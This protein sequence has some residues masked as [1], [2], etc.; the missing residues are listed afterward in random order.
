MGLGRI[1][2]IC[3]TL[4]SN[5]RQ[6]DTPV[7]VIQSGT[8]PQQREVY[9]SL[10]NI[11]AKVKDENISSPAIIIV[12]E[13]VGIKDKI[14]ISS[15]KPLSGA[16]VIVTRPQNQSSSFSKKLERLGAETVELAAVSIEENKFNTSCFDKLKDGYF[17][18]VIFT[19]RNGVTHTW[20]KLISL[21]M[22]TRIFG[23]AKVGAIGSATA[24]AL[25]GIGVIADVVPEKFIAE[26]LFESVCQFSGALAGKKILML[27]S[28]IARTNLKKLFEDAGSEVTEIA[29]Y[30]T[31]VNQ[32][33]IPAH[34]LKR[35]L[36]CTK[37]KF[38]TFTSSST[39]E[40]FCN[41]LENS[42]IK[43]ADIPEPVKL[44]SIGP[45][46]TA[47]MKANNLSADIEAEEYSTGGIVSAIIEECSQG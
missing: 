42:N 13:V 47:T 32:N 11:S 31:V 27:R 44:V 5:G 36:E 15:N 34:A 29:A 24:E 3:K 17:D 12:G 20:D 45:I 26:D 35:I 7:A 28:D 23:N 14:N 40:G 21:G 41:Y 37:K 9:G 10:E 2:K 16:M 46:T 33:P 22:D 1:E 38:I 39:V 18:W 4:I 19:S 43:I 8:L 30:R 25:R 6:K